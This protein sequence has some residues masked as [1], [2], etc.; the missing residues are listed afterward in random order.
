MTLVKPALANAEPGKPITAQAWNAVTGAI[1]TLYD[2]VAAMSGANVLVQVAANGVPVEGAEVL[3]VPQGEGRPILAAPAYPGVSAYTLAGV[4]PGTWT[5]HV[6]AAGFVSQ[7]INV[8]MPPAG[9]VNVNLVLAGVVMPDLF[10]M[11]TSQALAAIAAAG[12]QVDII[13]DAAGQEIPKT[14]LPPASANVPVL[15]HSP[16]AGSVLI[17]A[18]DRVRLVIAAAFQQASMVVMPN[19]TGLSLA[20]ATKALEGLGLKVGSTTIKN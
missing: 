10:G 20:E 1:G 12:L 9:P 19:L 5:V 3:A 18:S 16:A 15:M 6:S 14:S 7:A 8:S 11:P 4:T 2:A 13:L 17:P